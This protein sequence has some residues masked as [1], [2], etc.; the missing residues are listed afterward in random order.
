MPGKPLDIEKIRRN[1]RSEAPLEQ[2]AKG[3]VQVTPPLDPFLAAR[4]D[5]ERLRTLI[6]AD[7]EPH[8]E[9]LSLFL[10]RIDDALEKVEKVASGL[11]PGEDSITLRRELHDA[12]FRLEDLLEALS[13]P[14]R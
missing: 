3:V 8:F 12:L 1:W 6:H 10:Q 14:P 5:L 2:E 11:S 4:H 9:T 13:L 7:F